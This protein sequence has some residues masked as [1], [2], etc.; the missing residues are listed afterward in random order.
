MSKWGLTG[1][2][3]AAH[4][5]VRAHGARAAPRELATSWGT[6][7]YTSG[8]TWPLTQVIISNNLNNTNITKSNNTKKRKR[9]MVGHFRS[10]AARWLDEPVSFG[11]HLLLD[12]GGCGVLRYFVSFHFIS[13]HFISFHFISFHFISFYFILISFYFILFYFILFYFILF[14]FILFC[15]S[16]LLL[17]SPLSFFSPFSYETLK[18]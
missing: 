1:I 10:L 17:T 16:S 6:K 13:F 18:D 15:S 12:A 14:H 11:K 8:C 4:R 5:R 3:D 9:L 7:G 2:D